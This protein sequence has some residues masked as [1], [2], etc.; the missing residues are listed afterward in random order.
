[1]K[2]KNRHLVSKFHKRLSYS[3]VN[4]YCIKDPDFFKIEDILEKY[5][6][7]YRKIFVYFKIICEWDLY[8]ID[9]NIFVKRTDE[10]YIFFRIYNL[11]IF[12]LDKTTDYE[13]MGYIFSHISEMKIVFIS[14]YRSMTYEFYIKQPKSMLEWNLIKKNICKS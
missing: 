6:D 12:L 3:I 13:A 5:I 1:M 2:S 9:D 8:F 14:N 7:D 4:R 10:R 11:K